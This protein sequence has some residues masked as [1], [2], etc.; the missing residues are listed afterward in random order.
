[1]TGASA[2]RLPRSLLL[3][4]RNPHK[5]R[6]FGRLLGAA[7]I[8]VQ[9]LPDGVQLPPEVGETFADNALPKARA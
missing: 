2:A 3:S 1:M 6:E 7:G 9:P 4:T 5:L 8:E